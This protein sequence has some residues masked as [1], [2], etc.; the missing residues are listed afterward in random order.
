MCAY[1]YRKEI[2]YFEEAELPYGME[3][4]ECMGS[5]LE[6]AVQTNHFNLPFTISSSEFLV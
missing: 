5:M 3:P 2:A 6:E 1:R 4:N